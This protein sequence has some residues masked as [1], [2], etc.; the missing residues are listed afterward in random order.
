MVDQICSRLSD[1]RHLLE[2]VSSERSLQRTHDVDHA[3]V[4]RLHLRLRVT[5][6][7]RLTVP[8]S[9]ASGFS[10]SISSCCDSSRCARAAVCV[11]VAACTGRCEMLQCG[12]QRCMEAD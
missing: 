1:L 12:A 3:A 11:A 6:G 9:A 8:Q 5:F 2:V 7:Y 10:L 4:H